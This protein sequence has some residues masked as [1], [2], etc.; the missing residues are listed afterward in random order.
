ML[1]LKEPLA[2]VY[3]VAKLERGYHHLKDWNLTHEEIIKIYTSNSR[4]LGLNLN[5]P[6]QRAKAK[7]FTENLGCEVR[8][9][10]RR[11]PTAFFVSLTRRYLVRYDYLIS[12]GIKDFKLSSFLKTDEAFCRQD[13]KKSLNHY[14]PF[15]NEWQDTEGKHLLHELEQKTKQEK[16]LLI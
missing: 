16:Q 6:L 11:A 10:L 5:S 9:V 15:Y 8:V 3:S 7:F 13:T 2:L 14:I 4:I 12:I 1:I